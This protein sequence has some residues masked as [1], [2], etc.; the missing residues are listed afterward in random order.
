[1]KNF[2]PHLELSKLQP[3]VHHVGWLCPSES[4]KMFVLLFWNDQIGDWVPITVP[5][6][7]E[8]IKSLIEQLVEDGELSLGGMEDCQ[9]SKADIE[10]LKEQ[11]EQLKNPKNVLTFM[12]SVSSPSELPEASED[13][14]GHVYIIRFA[15]DGVDADGETE[16]DDLFYEYVCVETDDGG[17]AWEQLGNVN[18]V[19]SWAEN[20]GF[21]YTGTVDAIRNITPTKTAVVDGVSTAFPDVDAV[22]NKIISKVWFTT[23]TITLSSALA[24]SYEVGTQINYPKVAL[25]GTGSTDSV[26]SLKFDGGSVIETDGFDE[27][28]AKD[29]YA[30]AVEVA[31]G[32][33]TLAT[34]TGTYTDGDGDTKSLTKAEL[35]VTG[36]Y[37]SYA[38][39]ITW[40]KGNPPSVDTINSLLESGKLADV[41]EKFT[42]PTTSNAI[43]IVLHESY[44]NVTARNGN[45]NQEYSFDDAGSEYVIS[46]TSG[47]YHTWI[48]VLDDALSKGQ[49]ITVTAS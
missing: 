28:A 11:M 40:D 49:P 33:N 15:N 20:V 7:K 23:P 39:Q 24:A 31:H 36:V 8:E 47:K 25:K 27:M 37:K 48:K 22:L 43:I 29:L 4:G 6:S 13:N 34:V 2:I 16:G 42:T 14:V 5:I 45:T 17:Y 30:K 46:R 18:G 21:K 32:K 1:M 10:A 44:T 26:T 9:C 38:G 35:T 41:P 3:N 12:G 19:E